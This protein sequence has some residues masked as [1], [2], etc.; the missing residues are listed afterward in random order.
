[1][2]AAPPAVYDIRFNHSRRVSK[3]IAANEIAIWIAVI[4]WAQR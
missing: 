3:V 1:M 2:T 4:A